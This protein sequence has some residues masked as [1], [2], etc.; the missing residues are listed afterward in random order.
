MAKVYRLG[1]VVLALGLV[2]RVCRLRVGL[3]LVLRVYRRGGD[4]EGR[5]RTTVSTK[6]PCG[7]GR[8]TAEKTSE[9]ITYNLSECPPRIPD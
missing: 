3:G 7:G 6:D 4:G 5:G 1:S 9:P 2:L 8:G